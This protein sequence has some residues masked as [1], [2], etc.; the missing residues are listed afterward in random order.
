MGIRDS[1]SRL[2]EKLELRSTGRRR[3]PDDMGFGTDEEGVGPADSLPR[4]ELYVAAGGVHGREGGRSNA[5]GQ[6]VHSTGWLPRPDKPESVLNEREVGGGAGVEGG[7]VSQSYSHPRT[8]VGVVVGGG[9][10]R[11]GDADKEGGDHFHSRLS[12]PSTP[13][14]E[15]PDGA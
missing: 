12:T 5:D 4:P 14:S 15:N 1:F 8:D 7:E 10:G 2:K 13:R 3:K 11:G 6:Q 9:S